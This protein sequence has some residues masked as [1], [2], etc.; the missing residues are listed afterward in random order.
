MLFAYYF[1]NPRWMR[2]S[3]AIATHGQR[4]WVCHLRKPFAVKW[5]AQVLRASSVRDHAPRLI[6]VP[7]LAGDSMQ[8]K[9]PTGRYSVTCEYSVCVNVCSLQLL[10]F[11]IHDD[12]HKCILSIRIMFFFFSLFW[13]LQMPMALTTTWTLEPSPCTCHEANSTS[14]SV[15]RY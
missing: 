8:I 6:L 15:P 4:L 7:L 3:W 14:T 13:C 5:F 10:E 2:R 1:I 12:I 9:E 11:D